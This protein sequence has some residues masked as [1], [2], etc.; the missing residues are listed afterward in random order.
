[1]P[2]A[3]YTN[4]WQ[5]AKK[6][7]SELKIY[8]FLLTTL[9][10][11]CKEEHTNIESKVEK[12]NKIVLISINAPAKYTHL[13]KQDSIGKKLKD[14]S[15][16]KSFSNKNGFTYLDYMNNEQTW[17]PKPKVSDTVV[18]E[19]YSD[20]LELSTNNFFT[21]IKETFLVKNGD[22]VVFNY[23]HNIPNAEI[24]NRKVNDIELNYNN[25]RLENL[26]ENKYTSHLMIFSTLW[27]NGVKDY[28]QNS[29][30]YYKEAKNDYKREIEFLDSLYNSSTITKVNYNYRKDALNILMEKHKRLKNIKQWLEQNRTLKNKEIIEQ[31][32]GFNLS[33]TDS[34][35]NFSFF[36]DYLNY[37]SEYNLEFIEENNGNSGGFYI[38][39]RIRFDSILKDKRFN[40]V[41]KN[42]LLFNAYDGIGRNF[43]IKDKEKYFIKLQKNTTNREQLDK[44][45]KNYKLDFS[46][47]D[48]LILTDLKNDT[49]TFSNVLKNNKGKWLYVDFWA[50]WCK[51]C[52][53]TMPESIKLKKELKNENI[54]FIYLALNDKKENWEKAIKT[55][56]LSN[57]QNYFI[58]NGNVS[59]VI[60]DLGIKTIPHYLIYNPN[61][62]LINGFANRPGKGANEQLRKLI[63]KK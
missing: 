40:Q 39:S 46:R 14:S 57:S 19:Y 24:T 17:L 58:E 42:Y 33:K 21:S 16:A 44:L 20:Y 49:I 2:N 47:S 35:M 8:F 30:N 7:K 31:L 37:I 61:G 12:P 4:S 63:T 59:K 9:L 29:I 28:E 48:K 10:F 62:E 41:A 22:T 27:I 52:R 51:P 32:F 15:G 11:S 5:Q 26:F 6:M 53:E 56:S 3:S 38:D 13:L 1:M 23:K 55:D 45:Q 18:I 60:E 54:E 34:L 43:R 36:R 25:Y 50:S